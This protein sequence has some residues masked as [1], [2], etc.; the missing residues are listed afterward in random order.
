[1]C[2]PDDQLVFSDDQDHCDTIAHSQLGVSH[3]P[4]PVPTADPTLQP[5]Q[6]P[7]F[8]PT[9]S[10]TSEETPT[11][12]GYNLAYG[13]LDAFEAVVITL[14]GGVTLVVGTIMS[15]KQIVHNR[16]IAGSQPQGEGTSDG[17]G[18]ASQE[19]L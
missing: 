12:L 5:S 13:G 8:M 6:M 15:Y 4:T 14:L 3:A 18:M 11:L 1:M 10:P 17:Q 16:K 19:D 9:S 7:N 2:R